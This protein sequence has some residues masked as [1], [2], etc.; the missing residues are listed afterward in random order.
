MTQDNDHMTDLMKT[1]GYA[2]TQV[3]GAHLPQNIEM[4]FNQ[5]IFLNLRKENIAFQHLNEE[6]ERDRWFQKISNRVPDIRRT[7]R[8]LRYHCENVRDLEQ[9]I[10]EVSAPI[11]STAPEQRSF[12]VG[13]GEHEK[14]DAEYHAFHFAVARTLEYFTL[15]LSSLF[16][17]ETKSSVGYFPNLQR[18]NLLSRL[19]LSQSELDRLRMKLGISGKNQIPLS[20]LGIG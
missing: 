15:A 19:R 2:V 4:Y 18:L 8:I 5:I 11:L 9:R 13:A 17:M 20:R 10:G 14:L 16:R 1:L 6:G 7:L 12:T 3:A